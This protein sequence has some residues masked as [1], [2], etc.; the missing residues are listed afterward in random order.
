MSYSSQRKKK[1]ELNIFNQ[2]SQ[3]LEKY[4]QLASQDEFQDYCAE[5]PYNIKEITALEWWYQEQ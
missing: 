4:S 2:I 1:K 3:D 5:E